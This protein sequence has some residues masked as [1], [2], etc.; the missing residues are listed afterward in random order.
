MWCLACKR[1]W[2]PALLVSMRA[3]LP[4]RQSKRSKRG[5]RWP[6][7]CSPTSS[8][9]SAAAVPMT[10][11][12]PSRPSS[13]RAATSTTTRF[14]SSRLT[15]SRCRQR[16]RPSG[17]V[18]NFAQ[19]VVKGQSPLSVERLSGQGVEQYGRSE[20]LFAGLHHHLS[21][22]DH[23]H[24]LNSNECVLGCLERFKP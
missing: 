7:R 8:S 16:R 22:L 20:T 18:A 1:H 21:F 19:E 24:E 14:A 15:A 2:A 11:R 13:P 5:W 10:P 23:V 12:K 3:S 17:Y 4:M 9:A 6:K